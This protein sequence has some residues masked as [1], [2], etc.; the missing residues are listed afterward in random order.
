MITAAQVKEKISR[1]LE[2]KR[3]MQVSE[4]IEL[5]EVAAK[6]M[7]DNSTMI[8]VFSDDSHS[9]KI[10]WAQET[11]QKEYV[12]WIAETG[13]TFAKHYASN[14]YALFA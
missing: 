6:E 8:F 1:E 13:F 12:N 7:M 10:L 9:K 4:V 5:L 11:N 3:K 2:D 14:H